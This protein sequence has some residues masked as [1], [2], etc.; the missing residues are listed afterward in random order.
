MNIQ[1]GASNIKFTGVTSRL[2]RDFPAKLPSLIYDSFTLSK[3]AKAKKALFQ[4]RKFGVD[5]YRSMNSV[6]KSFFGFK[7]PQDI[8]QAAAASV[9]TALFLKEHLDQKYGKG[10][11]V[12]CCIGTSPS[13]L[14]RVFEFSGVETKYLPISDMSVCRNESLMKFYSTK[15]P[16]Y[17]KFLEEQGISQENVSKSSKTYLFYD[18]TCSGNSLDNFQVMM[19]EL[20]GIDADNVLFKSINGELDSCCE[21]D[22][23]YDK[24]AFRYVQDFMFYNKAEKLGG[25]PHLMLRHLDEISSCVPSDSIESRQF[26]FSVMEILSRRGLLRENPQNRFAL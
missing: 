20:V 4:E 23:E 15:V 22:E 3:E 10:K 1:S 5:D 9:D 8:K 17:S 6:E 7:I 2:N 14:A 13:T 11:Y 16:N 26:N 18:Y 25:V 12:F 24:H 21:T 19:N